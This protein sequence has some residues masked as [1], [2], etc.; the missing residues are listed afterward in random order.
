MFIYS[1]NIDQNVQMVLI[2]WI[3]IIVQK[4]QVIICESNLG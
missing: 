3:Q 4:V 2:Y 1:E